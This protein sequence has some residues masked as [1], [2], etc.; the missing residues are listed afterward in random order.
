MAKNNKSGLVVFIII[1]ALAVFSAVLGI[2][3]SVGFPQRNSTPSTN[4]NI[5]NFNPKNIRFP[6]FNQKS[7]NEFPKTKG[8][9]VAKLFIS[10]TIE[11]ANATYNQKWL[12]DTVSTLKNDNNNLGIILYI[13]S[14]GGGVYES[15]EAY[16][17]LKDYKTSGKPVYAYMSSLAASG[18]YYISCAADTIYANRNT[19]TGSIGVIA[20]GSMDL[21]GLMEGLG[22]KYT[23]IHAGKNKN[24]GNY[25]E[26]LTDEQRQIYQDIADEC[27]EQ[28]TSI[29]ASS[30]KMKLEDVVKLADGRIYTAKQ[31]QSNGLID[32][33]GTWDDAVSSIKNSK[34]FDNN[35]FEIVE[36]N[37][38]QKQNFYS[39]F[40]GVVKSLKKTASVNSTIQQE[41][42]ELLS[43]KTP[44]PA[45]FYDSGR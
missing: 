22:I 29:V 2:V 14:P 41:V 4:T 30:R 20:G 25:N 1:I 11:Q 17:A 6:L 8:R 9:Y 5:E 45:Y 31:A 7:T 37:Y 21:T 38:E 32:Y 13:D 34:K 33:I 27:Y 35:N 39:Y 24:M 42:L 44:Y 28:F 12:L 16:L 36:F 3:K 18:G 19:L 15:D 23:T 10:G 40:M 26:P 43:P